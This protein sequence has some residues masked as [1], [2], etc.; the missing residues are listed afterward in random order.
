MSLSEEEIFKLL[1]LAEQAYTARSFNEFSV[2]LP[3]VAQMTCL[4]SVLLYVSDSRLTSPV[5]LQYGFGPFEETQIAGMCNEQFQRMLEHPDRD[6]LR[7][8]ALEPWKE[9]ATSLYPLRLKETVIGM[10]GLRLEGDAA[11]RSEVW[12][13]LTAIF[14]NAIDRLADHSKTQR[15]LAHLTTYLTVSSMIAQPLGLNEVL[16]TIL[17]ACTEA[18]SAEGASILLLDENKERFVFYQVEGPSKPILKGA[19]FPADKGIAGVVLNTQRSEIINDVQAN[20]GFYGEIDLD[21]GFR[22]RSMIAIPL[23]AGEERI[24][25]LEVLN[26]TEGKSFNMEECLILYSIAEEIAYAMRNASVFEYIVNTYCKQRQG[27]ATCKGCK[28]P[29]GSWTPC[30]EVPT[31]HWHDC[32]TNLRRFRI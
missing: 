21:S 20:P 28:R 29:L 19:K 10:L 14:A 22:T 6:S 30:V 3:V 23:T 26:K 8:S 31:R 9:I 1:S 27:L 32:L 7:L 4:P 16:E 24:G 5:V 11:A 13:E 25:I 2:T 18:A 12:K 17:N 15:R